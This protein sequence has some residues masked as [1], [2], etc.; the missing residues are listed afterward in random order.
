MPLLPGLAHRQHLRDLTVRQRAFCVCPN[1][2]A[3]GCQGCRHRGGSPAGRVAFGRRW[4][5]HWAARRR[6]HSWPHL[7]AV[8][9]GTVPSHGLTYLHNSGSSAINHREGEPRRRAAPAHG[10]G[11]CSADHRQARVWRLGWPTAAARYQAELNGRGTPWPTERDYG[12]QHADLQVLQPTGAVH[13]TSNGRLL[14]RRRHQYHM[15]A[16][17]ALKSPCAV[18]AQAHES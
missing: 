3:T 9:P 4:D 7:R 17:Y 13:R 8:H 12:Q 14:L 1:H 18:S 2:Q 10:R 11:L 5:Q 15:R 16:Q 6:R